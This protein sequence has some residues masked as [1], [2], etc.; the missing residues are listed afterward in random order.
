MALRPL[1]T[2]EQK[3]VEWIE[4]SNNAFQHALFKICDRTIMRPP[5][6]EVYEFISL[7]MTT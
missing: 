7:L 6:V 3:P 2:F 5:F 1:G 4:L